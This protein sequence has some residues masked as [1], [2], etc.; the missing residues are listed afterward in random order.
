VLDEDAFAELAE[1]NLDEALTLLADL[2]GATDERLRALSMTLAAR[3]FCDLA[4][5]GTAR[6]RG[7]GKLERL[8][9]SRATGDLDIDASIIEFVEARAT[10]RAVRSE[11]LRVTT[12][13]KPHTAIAILVDRSGSMTGERVATAAVVAAAV[14]QRGAVG[15]ADASGS[16]EASVIAFNDTAIVLRS[17]DVNREAGEVV[18]DLL[19]LRGHGTTDLGLALRTAAA[20][21]G[22]STATRKLTVL[23]SDCRSTA[24][25][26]AVDDAAA[27]DELVIIAPTGDTEDAE[28]LADAVGAR[29]GDAATPTEAIDLLTRLLGE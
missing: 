9:A 10:R 12:W 28:A 3:V 14:L 29:L 18:T 20:Q 13:R 24:G 8:P 25:A 26:S 16:A 4:K 19:R 6:G 21:L 2:V 22:R 15:S 7:I 23:I 5:S 27:V 1:D 11:E 17:M